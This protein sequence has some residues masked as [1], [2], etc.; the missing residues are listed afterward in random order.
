[1]KNIITLL[2]ALVSFTLNA[3]TDSTIL[4]MDTT[5]KKVDTAETTEIDFGNVKVIIKDKKKKTITKDE[6]WK[7]NNE[8]GVDSDDDDED[9]F[10]SVSFKT[11]FGIGVAGY[12]S[13]TE[14][15][16]I[17]SPTS[18]ASLDLNYGKCRNYMING[19]L[20]FDIH[21]NFGILTGLGVEFNRYVFKDNLQVT[22]NEGE[23]V[24]DTAISYGSYKFKTNYL[25]IS[26]M[27]VFKSSNQ[28]L[29]FAVGGTFSY[30]IGNKVKLEYT[31][32]NVETE[33]KIKGNYN[34]APIK[35]SLG[36]RVAYKGIGLYVNYGLTEMN[37]N[38]ISHTSGY[39]N[40]THFSAGITLGGL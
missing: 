27:L 2:I 32:G 8:N 14:E 12:T 7:K 15:V 29:K 19:N 16:L 26:L 21:K 18:N 38:K 9:D 11:T 39:V 5:I 25:N 28:K 37:N 4:K 24:L 17:A 3:Q 30:N 35:L 23:F 6:N 1:M 13:T 10:P 31:E 34:V 40:L 22:P 36:A 33:S 20:I